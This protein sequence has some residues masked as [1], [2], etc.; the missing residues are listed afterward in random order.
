MKIKFTKQSIE[1]INNIYE[2][3]LNQSDRNTALKV[4]HKIKNV[5]DDLSIYT[6][7]GRKIKKDTRRL[8]IP[9]LPFVIIYKINITKKIVYIST[10]FHTARKL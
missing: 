4:I 8:V 1:D 10:I 7:L 6:N 2:Y 3:I 5:I 9:G